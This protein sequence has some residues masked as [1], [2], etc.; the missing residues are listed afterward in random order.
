MIILYIIIKKMVYPMIVKKKRFDDEFEELPAKNRP[1]KLKERAPVARAVEREPAPEAKSV[2]REPVP[3]AKAVERE[4]GPEA[5]ST[6]AGKGEAPLASATS[7]KGVT[8]TE[9]LERAYQQGDAYA[10]GDTLYVAGSWTA[11]DWYDDLTKV[12]FYG[13]LR[14]AT[15]YQQA[16]KALKANPNIKNVVGHSLGGSVALELQKNHPNLQSR[17]YGAPVWDPFGEDNKYKG[18]N[19]QV[20]RYRNVGDPFS[21]F[22]GSAK[23][24][25]KWNPFDSK[26]LTHDYSNIGTKF[27]GGGADHANGWQNPDG[28]TSLIQ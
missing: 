26:S 28:S 24:S 1:F 17:T 2:E 21:V 10:H 6:I 7:G 15:R 25:I 22:D 19:G 16:E 20:D 4:P 12:P 9:G 27:Q 18:F 11:K 23:T 8:D 14:N 3:V 5:K 13:D